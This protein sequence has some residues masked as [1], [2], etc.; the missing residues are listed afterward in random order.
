MFT[1]H[2]HSWKTYTGINPR[3]LAVNRF[4]LSDANK[5]Q[6]CINPFWTLDYVYSGS[7]LHR[8]GSERQPW[9]RRK[10]GEAHLH[11]PGCP[12]WEDLRL[13]PGQVVES[14]Y[15]V[16]EWNRPQSLRWDDGAGENA[17]GGTP[18]RSMR[19]HD[20]H[21]RLGRLLETLAAL[22]RDRGEEAFWEAQAMLFQAL[23]MLLASCP[24]EPDL[25]LIMSTDSETG[26]PDFLRRVDHYLQQHLAQTV[27]LDAVARY[28]HVSP[29]TLSHR[30]R[31]RT[32]R[33]PMAA[34]V[35][36]RVDLAKLML[37]KGHSLKTIAE[38]AGFCDAFHL[39]KT[40]KRLE[41]VSPNR[42]LAEQ[43]AR[44]GTK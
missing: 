22:G 25:R 11:A 8:L 21:G 24:V 35:R 23:A 41:G 33:S 38:A 1:L 26:E 31:E 20:P 5:V 18:P 7:G 10:P 6:Y 17:S 42:Y 29:S 39:S 37:T 40:F 27:T 43:Q 15:I 13:D 4:R 3:L 44:S 36:K 34:L 32:G 16:F 19:F 30:Y 28:L 12:Y 2:G 14:A 9:I